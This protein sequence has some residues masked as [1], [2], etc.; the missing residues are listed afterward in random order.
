MWKRLRCLEPVADGF[1]N[2]LKGKYAVSAEEMLLDKAQ[3]LTLTA[4]EMTVL[5]GGMRVLNAAFTQ[6][7]EA[8][9]TDFFVNLVDMSTDWQ[10]TADDNVF[11][12]RD[13]ATGAVKWTGSRVD[14]VFGSNSQLRAV[15]EVYAQNDSKEKF[16]HDFV[17][18]WNKVMNLD[19]FD[20]A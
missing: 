5:V 16:V 8:L 13:R 19:R 10:A 4:P 7:P 2:Y 11:E 3:L 17:A 9:T 18:A 6:R 12:G 14:L 20:L 1:R 15:A